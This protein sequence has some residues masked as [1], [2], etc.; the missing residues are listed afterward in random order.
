LTDPEGHGQISAA[1]L[2]YKSIYIYI[3]SGLATDS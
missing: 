2:S 1:R 3:R